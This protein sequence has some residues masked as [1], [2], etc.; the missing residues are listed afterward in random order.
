M[1]EQILRVGVVY[2]VEPLASVCGVTNAPR[3]RWPGI[4][5]NGES[6]ILKYK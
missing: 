2:G 5:V 6:F 1:I 4:Q 3:C